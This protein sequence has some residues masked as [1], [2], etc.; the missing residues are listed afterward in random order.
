MV[1]ENMLKKKYDHFCKNFRYFITACFSKTHRAN[2][3]IQWKIYIILQTQEKKGEFNSSFSS[4]Q[5][6]M[7]FQSLISTLFCKEN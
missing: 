6:I 7:D 2:T 4:Q 1:K 3:V 5:K